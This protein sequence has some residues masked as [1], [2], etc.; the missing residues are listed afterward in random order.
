MSAAAPA[1]QIRHVEAEAEVRACFALMRQLRPHLASAD[2]FVARWRRQQGA[3]YRLLALW[4]EGRPAAL[5]GYR[6]LDNL[7]HGVHCYVDDLVTDEGQRS[8]G[9]GAAMMDRLKAEA[10]ALG[11]GRLLLDTGL[12]NALGQRFYFRNGLLATAL[13]FMI[14]LD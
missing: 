6:V 14:P 3:G 13:R 2:E 4:Q 12:A 10:R 8:G 5:A 11:C 7:T 1:G 9:Y